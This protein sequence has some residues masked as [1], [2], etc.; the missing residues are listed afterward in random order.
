MQC[1]LI[2]RNHSILSYIVIFFA[3]VDDGER[4]YGSP[5]ARH[6]QVYGDPLAPVLLFESE[7]IVD[8][9]AVVAGQSH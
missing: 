7:V 6:S 8:K 2:I 9:M 5:A 3:D 1:S 4:R